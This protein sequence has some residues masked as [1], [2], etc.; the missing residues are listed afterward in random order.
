[1]SV[2]AIYLEATLNTAAV[3]RHHEVAN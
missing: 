3:A 1:M 2:S